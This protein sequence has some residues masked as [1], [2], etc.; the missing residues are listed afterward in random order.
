MIHE[1]Q[2]IADHFA[3]VTSGR[4]SFIMQKETDAQYTVGDFLALNEVT[5]EDGAVVTTGRCC[6]VQVVYI[7]SG[8]GRYLQ[9]GAIVMS[10]R[11]CA[12]LT[13]EDVK[14]RFTHDL[15]EVDVYGGPEVGARS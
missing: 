6:L 5:E 7:Y 1:I 9:P 10:V 14:A 3:A 13:Y 12:I 15:F 8:A 2:C 4:K 11:P